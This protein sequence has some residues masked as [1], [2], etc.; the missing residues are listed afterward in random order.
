[1]K[2]N[3]EN[4]NPMNNLKTSPVNKNIT[5]FLYEKIKC[6]DID[7]KYVPEKY[8]RVIRELLLEEKRL[9]TEKLNEFKKL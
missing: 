4:E 8:L 6:G 9:K 5:L 7:S 2:S 3:F 1:M